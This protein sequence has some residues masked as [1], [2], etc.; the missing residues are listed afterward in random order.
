MCQDCLIQK[1]IP[2]CEIRL[3]FH[4]PNRHSYTVA[5]ANI[6]QFHGHSLLIQRDDPE[7]KQLN[8]ANRNEGSTAIAFIQVIS[9]GD[10]QSQ[11]THG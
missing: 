7:T 2:L 8:T 11:H 6:S 1:P 4:D 9:H 3:N 5:E 10:A